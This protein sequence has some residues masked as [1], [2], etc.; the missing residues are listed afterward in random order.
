MAMFGTVPEP[1][2]SAMMILCFLGVAW[3]C[4]LSPEVKAGVKA[5]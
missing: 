4:G 1:S 3:R 2:T 5:A